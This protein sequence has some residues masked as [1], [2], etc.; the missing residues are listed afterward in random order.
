[1]KKL[2]P[3]PFIIL[4]F[5]SQGFLFL[6]FIVT[7]GGVFLFSGFAKHIIY[8]LLL[9]PL[10]LIIFALLIPKNNI[11]TAIAV[12]VAAGIFYIFTFGFF[13]ASVLFAFSMLYLFYAF[14]FVYRRRALAINA[15]IGTLIILPLTILE[16]VFPY[17]LMFYLFL[18]VSWFAFT[19]FYISLLGGRIELRKI[20]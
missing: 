18:P 12:C 6:S 1:M 11:R 15:G 16:L 9:N 14:A 19:V 17:F 13:I 2:N 3:K 20:P 4:G 8:F 10:I 7:L 5:I